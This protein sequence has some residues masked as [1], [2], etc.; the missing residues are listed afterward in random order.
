LKRVTHDSPDHPKAKT[1]PAAE[2]KTVVWRQMASTLDQN[3]EWAQ[4]IYTAPGATWKRDLDTGKTCYSDTLNIGDPALIG[5]KL[6]AKYL[7]GP[8]GA[9]GV[10]LI[11]IN[12]DHPAIPW[13][14]TQ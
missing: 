10:W 5:G 13:T 12:L 8:N 1:F 9:G 7:N 6:Y 14:C 3:P 11:E 2:G 4:E